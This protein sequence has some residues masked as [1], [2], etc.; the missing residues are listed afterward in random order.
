MLPL[1]VADMSRTKQHINRSTVS[2]ARSE[3]YDS[4]VVLNCGAQNHRKCVFSRAP[5][6]MQGRSHV[7]P[8]L[9]EFS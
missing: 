2:G 4:H 9:I 5:V 8:W 7:W 3:V 6:S 1:T